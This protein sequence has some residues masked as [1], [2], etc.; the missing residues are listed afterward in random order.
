M[1]ILIFLL[2]VLFGQFL[3]LHV[4]RHGKGL[5]PALVFIL[6]SLI[7]LLMMVFTYFPPEIPWFQDAVTGKYGIAAAS[8]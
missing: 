8:S 3:G 2:C 4:Y 7:V 6:F 1:D 5:P